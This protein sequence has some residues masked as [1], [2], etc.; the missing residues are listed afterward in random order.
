MSW[1]WRWEVPLL[2]RKYLAALGILEGTVRI[3]QLR[4]YFDEWEIWNVPRAYVRAPQIA[5]QADQIGHGLS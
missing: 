2:R 4:R 5:I 3:C 1:K